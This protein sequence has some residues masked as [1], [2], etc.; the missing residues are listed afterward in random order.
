LHGGFLKAFGHALPQGD[1]AS[2]IPFP[3]LL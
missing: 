1:T 2:T 3:N